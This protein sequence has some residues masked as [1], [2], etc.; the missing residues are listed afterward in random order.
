M[1]MTGTLDDFCDELM[2]DESLSA[3]RMEPERLAADFPRFFRSVGK[4]HAG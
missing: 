3:R 1:N 4:A 2:N